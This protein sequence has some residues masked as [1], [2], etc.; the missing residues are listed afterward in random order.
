MNCQL[1]R[2]VYGAV[3]LLGEK[4]CFFLQDIFIDVLKALPDKGM[5]ALV[6][7]FDFFK[8]GILSCLRLVLFF[9]PSALRLTL[10][11][12]SLVWF[13]LGRFRV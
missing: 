7:K 4:F 11:E 10:H 9:S 5:M 3:S 13:Q 6:N 2:D 8:T 1:R 12:G